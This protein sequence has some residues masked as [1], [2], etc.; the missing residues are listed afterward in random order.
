VARQP[1]LDGEEKV[2]GYELLFRDGMENAFAGDSDEASRATLDRSLVMGLDVLCDGRR[3]FINCTRDTLMKGL[4]TLLPSAST[5]VEV[6]ETVP[7]DPDVIAA[8]QSLKERGC[9]IALDDFVANDTCE[10]L[11]DMADIIKVDMKLASVAER[12]PSRKSSD[13]GVIACWP[14]KLKPAMNSPR[15]AIK[16]WSTFRAFSSAVRKN[17]RPTTCPAIA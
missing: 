13:P 3:A 8:C 9:T 2:F 14:K 16:A 5:V 11:T 17:L 4:V 6:L 7:A 15:R 12:S 1:I 10:A